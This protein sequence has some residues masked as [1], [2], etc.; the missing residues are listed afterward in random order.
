MP[1]HSVVRLLTQSIRLAK[2]GLKS[3]ISHFNYSKLMLYGYYM[4]FVEAFTQNG[5]LS[6]KC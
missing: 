2:F 6:N 1:F 3:K 4:Y 5:M